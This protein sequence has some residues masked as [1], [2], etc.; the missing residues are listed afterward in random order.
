MK[1]FWHLRW[2]SLG[3]CIGL[4][5]L[6]VACAGS[7]DSDVKFN[8]EAFPCE[9][10]Q[11]ASADTSSEAEDAEVL[12]LLGITKESEKTQT[13]TEAAEPAAG[14]NMQELKTKLNDL[15]KEAR[16]KNVELDNLKSELAE[17]DRRLSD[18][19]SELAKPQKQAGAATSSTD[20]SFKARY[21]AALGMYNSRKY[22]QAINMFDELL[23]LNVSNSLTDNCQYWKGEA[24]YAMDD[25]NQ[26]IM[27]FEKVFVFN[28]SNKADAAQLKLGL[29]YLKLGNKEKARNEL[30]KLLSGYPTSE[31]IPKA[32]TYLANL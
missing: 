7:R 29:C 12:R 13:A 25:Y 26:A 23:A 3:L 14:A 24:Y 16:Q 15:E 31:Y 4:F 27:E 18:L 32:Q 22:K 5:S 11:G 1:N 6:L 17:R 9:S 30:Q 20:G 8:E 28:N 19:Q 10:D 2:L 21:D